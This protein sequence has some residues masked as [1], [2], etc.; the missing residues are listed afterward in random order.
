MVIDNHMILTT[1]GMLLYNKVQAGAK[2]QFTKIKVGSGKLVENDNP[3]NFTDL[4]EHQYDVPITS[5]TNNTKLQKAI[6]E[7]IINNSNMIEGKYICEIGV[8]AN[9]PDEGEIL[10]SYANANEKGDWFAPSASGA[11]SWFYQIYAAIGNAENV[12]ATVSEI[13]YDH[14]VI[15]S[16]T[17]LTIINGTNQRE[18]NENI[19]EYLK[20][21]PKIT[22]GTLEPSNPKA[23]DIWCKTV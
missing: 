20:T 10:Y 16:S 21:V 7:G 11:F 23:N 15:N 14:S 8:F 6:I 5:V 22:I 18:I 19:D 17:D 2:L 13:I 1:K 3:E 4:K 12:T 9:D